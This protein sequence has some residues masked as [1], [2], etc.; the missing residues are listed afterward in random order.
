MQ[1]SINLK[2]HGKRAYCARHWHYAF[3]SMGNRLEANGEEYTTNALNQIVTKENNSRHIS[4]LGVPGMKVV[5]TGSSGIVVSANTGTQGRFWSTEIV[6]DNEAA[7]A[8]TGITLWFGKKNGAST[9]EDLLARIDH[10]DDAN[11]AVFMPP[12][13]EIMQYDADGNLIKDGRWIYTYDALNQLV[14]METRDAT[15]RDILASITQGDKPR[16]IEFAYDYLGR[17]IAKVVKDYDTQQVISNHRYIYQ[18]WN[19]IAELDAAWDASTS[20]LNVNWK[21]SFHWGLDIVGTLT[22][23]GG[24][25]ALLMIQDGNNQYYP[26]YDGNGNVTG[27]LD[28]SGNAVAKYEYSPFG[29]LLRCEGNYAKKNPF[30]WSTKWADRETG[31]VYYGRRYYDPRLGR[32]VSRD[33]IEEMGGLNV[34]DFLGNSPIGRWDML[35]LDF[36]TTDPRQDQWDDDVVL[37]DRFDVNSNRWTAEDEYWYQSMYGNP[38]YGLVQ[39][40][41]NTGFPEFDSS[42]GGGGGG[43]EDYGKIVIMEKMV[44]TAN[45]IKNP[46]KNFQVPSGSTSILLPITSAGDVD[47]LNAMPDNMK[48]YLCQN[49]LSNNPAIQREIYGSRQFTDNNQ[50][51]RDYYREHGVAAGM[52]ADTT[53]TEIK[54]DLVTSTGKWT[55]VPDPPGTLPNVYEYDPRS[56]SSYITM[57]RAGSAGAWF[58]VSVNPKQFVSGANGY[59]YPFLIYNYHTHPS[60]PAFQ[61]E[62][63]GQDKSSYSSQKAPAY[64]NPR[65][66]NGGTNYVTVPVVGGAF[67]GLSQTFYGSNMGRQ[68]QMSFAEMRRILN[69]DARQA[70]ALDAALTEFFGP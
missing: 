18:G 60:H 20:T 58:S 23:S 57:E 42:G 35:G 31:L 46:F 33:P 30:Q 40:P 12:S 32:W 25:G 68:F 13:P 28:N 48:L 69:C 15:T 37:L 17:R 22:Q 3:D 66:P 14:A 2:Q 61:A 62:L 43:P 39:D 53:G 19:V 56:N 36:D 64:S 34:Y 67:H 27:L 7:A 45:R 11:L 1:I 29:E 70:R 41:F 59:L 8:K 26:A 47:M 63:S 16:R 21:R 24:V 50:V 44:V 65:S 55:H 9:G 6:L 54:G 49:Y 5:A 51:T 4:G 52:Y 38:G 10:E